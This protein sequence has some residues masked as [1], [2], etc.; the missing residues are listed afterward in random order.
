MTAGSY[1]AADIT[2]D[3]QGRLTSAASGS[4]G[5][6]G[7]VAGSDTEVQ[8]NNGGAFGASSDLTW[9]DTHLKPKNLAFPIKTLTDA[10]TVTLS[11]DD[12][13]LQTLDADRSSI[14]LATSN[15]AAGKTL[16]LRLKNINSDG[17]SSLTVTGASWIQI[18]D[19]AN[20]FSSGSYLSNAKTVILKLTC[21][22]TAETDI[23][24]EWADESA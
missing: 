5:G 23:T 14:T 10:A 20:T 21:W 6:G 19:G 2:V 7:S 18:P 4:G 1:T 16:T 22:G 9:D 11:F 8:F 24:A 13:H 3:A 17:F 12:E 15:R